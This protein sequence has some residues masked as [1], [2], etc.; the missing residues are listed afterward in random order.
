MTSPLDVTMVE[1]GRRLASQ[2]NR[3]TAHPLFIVQQKE[4]IYGFDPIWDVDPERA[5]WLHDG[6]E[7]D[8]EKRA[9]LES[10]YEETGEEPGDYTR[11]SYVDRW[12]FV[13]CC[14][15]EAAAQG[16]IE[17]Q[18]HNLK[19][20]RVYADSLNRN[21]EMIALRKHLG[22]LATE[23]DRLRWQCSGCHWGF[24]DRLRRGVCPACG[25]EGYW[26]GSVHPDAKLWP[27][28][29]P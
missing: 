24:R 2:D 26:T 4:R 12:E 8:A 19:D 6:E 18:R 25:R 29:Q 7:V 17:A 14:L 16:Y 28:V 11:T 23:A 15:T 1:I 22:E 20:P 10:T 5:V 3:A 27:G 21:P 13:T 9:E